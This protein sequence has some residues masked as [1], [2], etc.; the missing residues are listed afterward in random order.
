M[1]ALLDG[2]PTNR[3]NNDSR[4]C[5]AMRHF[6]QA[7][8]I[9]ALTGVLTA[10][11]NAM[12]PVWL[13]N[14]SQI[15][16]AIVVEELKKRD[17]Q[18]LEQFAFQVILFAESPRNYVPKSYDWDQC[19]HSSLSRY[20]VT[21]NRHS[22]V[23]IHELLDYTWLDP[24]Q[25]AK[26]TT[27]REDGEMPYLSLADALYGLKTPTFYAEREREALLYFDTDG[28]IWERKFHS[29]RLALY[30][31][32]LTGRRGYMPFLLED[33]ILF[34]SGRGFSY[35]ELAPVAL[36]TRPD[37][38]WELRA[39]G[40]YPNYPF[41]PDQSDRSEWH[42]D[43]WRLII[44]PATYLVRE[45]YWG[46]K[47]MVRTEG[48]RGSQL[49]VA[50]VGVRTF[51]LFR[52]TVSFEQVEPVFQEEWYR[53]V[54]NRIQLADVEWAYVDDYRFTEDTPITYTYKKQP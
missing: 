47:L 32:D 51:D 2:N 41:F 17:Q 20:K 40:Y 14:T 43:E 21:A 22:V 4:R 33:T 16:A 5:E 18:L 28:R 48:T 23:M 26:Y 8:A 15:E 37:G 54:V 13:P 45:A 3:E 49:P 27:P 38:L 34:C 25:I 6:R 9:L 50:A 39:K 44:E 46:G 11:S 52:L 35:A 1:I 10:N 24:D 53:E 31:P 42:Y 7:I 19:L 12:L 30:R 29:H 36:S